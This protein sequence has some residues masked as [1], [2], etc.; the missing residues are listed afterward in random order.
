MIFILLSSLTLVLST[1][2]GVGCISNQ[3]GVN[4]E[5]SRECTERLF[6]F[7]IESICITWFTIEYLIRLYAAPN[8]SKFFRSILNTIDL[9]SILPFYISVLLDLIYRDNIKDLKS[10]R[11]ATEILRVLR[12]MRILKLARHSSGLQL[13]GYSLKKSYKE[14][15]MLGMFLSI[16]ILLFS[17]TVYFAEKEVN[18]EQFQ[19]IPHAF[20]WAIIVSELYEIFSQ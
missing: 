12:V 6:V 1:I 10:I 15:S 13:L 17:S 20:W 7:L 11:K 19:S 14:L 5:D 9:I 2:E 18:A 3:T 4:G 16:F 8:K